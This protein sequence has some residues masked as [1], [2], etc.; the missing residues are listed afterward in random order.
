MAVTIAIFTAV[1]A[2]IA[3]III[4]VVTSNADIDAMRQRRC[5]KPD[6]DSSQ[7]TD[8]ANQ[9]EIQS[10]ERKVSSHKFCRFL[11]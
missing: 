3:G 8:C 2:A 6:T 9:E 10:G 4:P 5:Q 1:M 7:K 11:F